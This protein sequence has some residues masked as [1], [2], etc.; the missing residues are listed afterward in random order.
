MGYCK[1]NCGNDCSRCNRFEPDILRDAA[2]EDFRSGRS[3]SPLSKYE[4]NKTK[5]HKKDD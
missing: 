5:K 1:L 4:I 2:E 3:R